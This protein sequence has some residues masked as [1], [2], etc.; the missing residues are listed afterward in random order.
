[1]KKGEIYKLEIE[2]MSSE[3]QGIGRVFD[4][5]DE[6]RAGSLVVFVPGVIPGD[7]VKVELTRVKKNYAFGRPIE[8]IEE[9]PE[10]SE[11]SY[12]KYALALFTGETQV[13]ISC[14]G[15]PYAGINY[16]LQLAIKENQVKNK[17]VRIAGAREELINSI[18]P[19]DFAFRYRNKAAMAISTGGLMTRKGGIVEPV[20]EP[21]IGFRPAKSKEVM[22]CDNCAIQAETAN[23]AAE[24]TR[25]Y[26][27]EDNIPSFDTRWDKGLMKNMVVKT[28]FGTG[29]VMVVYEI[30]GKG[31]PNGAKLIEYL[32]DRIYEVG[33]NLESVVIKTDKGNSTL[34]GKPT[35][36]DVVTVYD[37]LEYA[38][39]S[40]EDESIQGRELSFEI[41]PDSF[42]QVDLVLQYPLHLPLAS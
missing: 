41:S 21:R 7:I 28:A 4:N 19:A 27:L 18:V 30:H 31:I 9:S 12:C 15:C 25:R 26:M 3:G 2:D 14:G 42:Y 40:M 5:E 8:L 29:E 20:H 37:S 33:A 10:R 36:T 34:A 16:D 32:D 22:N 39:N 6:D 17:L 23:A 1:M 24:A 11:K 38:C 13:G 35:I